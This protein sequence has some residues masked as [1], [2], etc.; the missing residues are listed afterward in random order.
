MVNE[1]I[2]IS[3]LKTDSLKKYNRYIWNNQEYLSYVDKYLSKIKDTTVRKELGS[4][5]ENFKNRYKTKIS[6]HQVLREKLNQL[7]QKLNDQ[8]IIMKLLIT[9]SIINNYQDNEIPEKA[10]IKSVIAR[11]DT[12]LKA[13]K[14]YNSKIK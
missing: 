10:R 11:Y 1:T 9:H 4:F 8:K 3:H 7:T 13:L 6:S 14:N 2:S 5:F 12:L